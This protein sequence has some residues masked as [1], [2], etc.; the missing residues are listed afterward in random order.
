MDKSKVVELITR[1]KAE[2]FFQLNGMSDEQVVLK[3]EHWYECLKDY[4]NEQVMDGFK[5]ALMKKDG[6]P[7]IADLVSFIQKAERINQPSDNE[8]WSLLLNGVNMIKTT[9]VQETPSSMYRKAL[10][11]LKDKS[12]CKEVYDRLPVEIQKAID[13]QTFVLYGGLDEKSLSI[14]RNRFLKAIPEI[15]TAVLEKKMVG[16]NNLAGKANKR[17][18][19]KNENV[20]AKRIT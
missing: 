16:S 14:E 9:F 1:I 12:R 6:P 2:Y 8:L 4:S 13:F 11:E 10:Y 19:C 7:T 15:R 5:I 3:A 18:V 17:L 20:S